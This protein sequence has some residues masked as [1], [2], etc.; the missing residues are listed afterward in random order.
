MSVRAESSSLVTDHRPQAT[1]SWHGLSLALPEDCG[2]VKLEGDESKGAVLIADLKSPRIGLRWTTI[3]KRADPAKLVR[4]ALRN[5]IGQLA[6]D[7][8]VT[9]TPSGVFTHGLLYIERDP[10]GRDVFV[11]FSQ[12]TRRIVEVVLHVR[13]IG[14]VDE[15]KPKQKRERELPA[16]FITADLLSTLRDDAP[17]TRW[18]VFDLNFTLPDTGWT[19]SKQRLNAGDLTMEFTKKR[20]TLIIR[21]IGPATLA[22]K[23]Q[24]AK[25]WVTI[26]GMLWK[27]MYKPGRES[28]VVSREEKPVAAV[29]LVRRRRFF[30]ARW[31]PSS[32]TIEMHRDE[33]RDRLVL[34]DSDD[35]SLIAKVLPTVGTT[36]EA[37]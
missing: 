25:Q 32:R 37:A 33:Q 8:A 14:E 15:K 22:L 2:P 17:R 20:H 31:A 4:A 18:S 11:G 26:H 23:R 36:R 1:L 9:H 29:T 12:A 30:F 13:A 10:P 27:Q 5:E 19:L 16:D 6:S 24:D 28:R 21:Q 34:I 3:S 7:E 35:P